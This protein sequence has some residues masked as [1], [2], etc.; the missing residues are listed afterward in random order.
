LHINKRGARVI[1][2]KR[3]AREYLY[4]IAFAFAGF[5]LMLIARTQ[6][7]WEHGYQ[8]YTERWEYYPQLVPIPYFG[9]LFVRSVMWAW[10]TV[11]RSQD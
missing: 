5:L 10:R 9:F 8:R 1:S 4:L 2:K 3:L 7:G 6:I 11:K